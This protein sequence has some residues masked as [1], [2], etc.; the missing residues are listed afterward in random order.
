MVDWLDRWK[1][2]TTGWH[3][4]DINPQLIENINQ[5][6]KARPQKI[7]VPLCGASLDM[8]YLSDQGFHVVGVEL[9]SLAI[10]RFFNENKIAY[11]VS[12]MEDFD[13]YQGKNIDIYCGDF[14]RLKKNYLNGAS[15]VYDRAAL[16]ALNP[17]LQKKY[18][19]HLKDILPNSSK[20]LLLTMFYPQN[21][22]EGPPYSVSDGSVE[23]LFSDSKEI[24]KISSVN[25]KESSLKPDD[26]NLTYLF[27]NVYLIE[28]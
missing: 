28:L 25:E 8:K 12:K 22:M 10:D 13:L 3:R 7:F 4:S 9:S 26:L 23:D 16:I 18:V 17:D 14:F 1:K 20:I 24:K 2:G 5:L 27:K 21:E 11:K 19:R 15:C 6:A